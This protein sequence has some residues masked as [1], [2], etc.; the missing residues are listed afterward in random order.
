MTSFPRVV[1]RARQ[2]NRLTVSLT[3]RTLPSANPTFTPPGCLLRA[4]FVIETIEGASA[5]GGLP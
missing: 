2:V 4:A 3:Y 5:Q 1:L